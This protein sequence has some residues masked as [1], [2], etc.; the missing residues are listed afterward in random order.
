M[1]FQTII[2]GYGAGEVYNLDEVYTLESVK[3]K[4]PYREKRIFSDAVNSYVKDLYEIENKMRGE[5]KQIVAAHRYLVSDPVVTN[6]VIARIN[7]FKETAGYAY[8]KVVDGHINNLSRS[9]DSI[10]KERIA[11]FEDVKNQV[12]SRIYNKQ[13]K[14]NFTKPTILIVN[15]VL[16]SMILNL[17]KNIK[18][19]IARKGSKLSHAAILTKEKG[20]PL[21][22]IKNINEKNGTFIAIDTKEKLIHVNPSLEDKKTYLTREKSNTSHV[23]VRKKAYLNDFNLQLNIS[24]PEDFLSSSLNQVNG[25]G[26]FRTE[27]IF[28]KAPQY[29]SLEEQVEIYEQVANK[30]YPK[31]VNIRLVDFKGDKAPLY[32]KH[33]ILDEFLFFGPLNQVYSEQIEAIIRA[34]E[35]YG[36]LRIMIPMIKHIAEYTHVKQYVNQL[37]DTLNMVRRTPALKLGI[38][39]ETLEAF[40]NINDFKIVDF[41]SIGTND[42]GSE[43]CMTNRDQIVDYKLHTRSLIEP[44]KLI[45]KFSKRHQIPY[46]IC[47]DLASNPNS[48]NKL[49]R[50][51]E[52]SFSFPESFLNQAI[53]LIKNY[54]IEQKNNK[55]FRK[56]TKTI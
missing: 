16:P 35:K 1:R 14:Q 10:L 4:N 22:V 3:C 38:M 33:L 52:T 12:L 23:N 7:D 21:I 27:H 20:I 5:A 19:I 39:M 6:S 46:S 40:E 44:I 56:S 36:N 17:S 11:D 26:L 32:L 18:G 29:L 2:E 31:Y 25:I 42:L 37:L 15:E 13:F 43:L 53:Y 47:G 24:S 8:I 30:A 55:D 45:S 28:L 54:K 51:Q 50:S 41:I 9:S 48:F 34:N 49:L